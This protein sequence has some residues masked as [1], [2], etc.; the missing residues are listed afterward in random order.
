MFILPWSAQRSVGPQ[1]E[2]GWLA[3]LGWVGTLLRVLVSMATVVM[4]TMWWWW[5]YAVNKGEYSIYIDIYTYI[6]IYIYICIYIDVYICI[7][8]RKPTILFHSIVPV[9]FL[10]VCLLCIAMFN[11]LSLCRSLPPFKQ[12][13]QQQL[14]TGLEWMEKYF[15]KNYILLEYNI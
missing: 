8:K 4:A 15:W 14:S 1:R 5:L 3:T 13:Q 11:N 9:L 12:Q 7:N 10:F 6:Y 2:M